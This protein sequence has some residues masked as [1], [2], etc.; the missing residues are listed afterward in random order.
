MR[1]IGLV[2]LVFVLGCG[3]NSGEVKE[4]DTQSTLDSTQDFGPLPDVPDHLFDI[5][6]DFGQDDVQSTGDGLDDQL[7][8]DSES[9]MVG[10]DS[11]QNETLSDGAC[12]PACTNTDGSAIEC[13]PDGCGS[14]CGY[15]GYGE[16]CVAIEGNKGK[17]VEACMPQCIGKQCGPDGCYGEC[18]PGCDSG[19]SCGDDGKCYPA[20]DHV[21]NC[22]GKQCGPD[23]CGGTC[24]T[25]GLG[26]VCNEAQGVCVADPCAAV[27]TKGKCL[28]GNILQTCEDGEIVET[29]CPS[30]GEDFYCK[31]DAVA[32]QYVCAQGCVPQCT[33]ESGTLKECGADGCNGFCGTCPSGWACENDLCAP[34]AGAAC[35]WVTATGTCISDV[36]WFCNGGIL[37][38]QNC[39]SLNKHCAYDPSQTKFQCL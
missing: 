13:G 17:C 28:V 18:P 9:E 16:Q 22:M 12:V 33:T 26:M 27:G 29:N 24:G 35:G 32:Q 11:Q 39:P 1:R 31:W 2:L 23:N 25:C 4:L 8:E 14:L 36:L 10:P 37:Y 7:P 30:L 3:S 38:T 19:F 6:K 20:C 34:E 15:C 21:A 5:V